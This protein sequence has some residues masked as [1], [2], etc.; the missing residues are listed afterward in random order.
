MQQWVTY[1]RASLQCFYL[2]HTVQVGFEGTTSS[3]NLAPRLELLLSGVRVLKCV[4]MIEKHSQ[5]RDTRRVLP[6]TTKENITKRE[7]EKP[8]RDCGLRPSQH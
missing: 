1:P 7:K 6:L 4:A 3:K 2:L 8:Q 5:Y